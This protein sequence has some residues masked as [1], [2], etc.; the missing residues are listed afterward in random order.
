N[1]LHLVDVLAN[2][3]HDE[4]RGRTYSSVYSPANQRYDLAS[5]QKYATLRGEF[6]GWGGGASDEKTTVVQKGDGFNAQIFVPVWT[7]ELLVS[8][9][10]QSSPVPLQVTA[11]TQGSG[12]QIKVDNRT[13]RKFAAIQ[14]VV[15]DRI[16]SLGEVPAMETRTFNSSRDD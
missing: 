15:G 6:V 2:G 10:W 12:W 14:L 1:E 4:L 5:Q 7:S 9:W 3:D 16:M 11:Q 13:D 8:D